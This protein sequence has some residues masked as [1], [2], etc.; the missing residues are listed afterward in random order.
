MYLYSYRLQ[1]YYLA[2]TAIQVMEL[3]EFFC[4][5][6][7]IFLLKTIFKFRNQVNIFS[8][9]QHTQHIPVC[10]MFYV[11]LNIHLVV[12]YQLTQR[13]VLSDQTHK[14]GRY[15]PVSNCVDNFQNSHYH[16][17]LQR[18]EK[19]ATYTSGYIFLHGCSGYN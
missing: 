1:Q 15:S 5:L 8:G 12:K 2:V 10:F 16:K 9:I 13:I 7:L 14:N 11:L 19:S 18:V 6:H 4:V 17:V 3:S